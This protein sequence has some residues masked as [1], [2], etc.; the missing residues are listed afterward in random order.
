MITDKLFRIVSVSAALS[1]ILVVALLAGNLAYESYPALRYLGLHVLVDS[2]D[3]A[4]SSYG[5]ASPLITS[6]MLVAITLTLSLP[7]AILF[8]LYVVFYMK[9]S[10]TRGYTRIMIEVLAGIPSVVYGAWGLYSLI[11]LINNYI[12]PVIGSTL[13]EHVSFFEFKPS[14]TGSLAAAS[15]VLTIMVI[16]VMVFTFTE[17][18]SNIPRS[19]YEACLATGATRWQAIKTYVLPASL[20]GIVAGI[21]LAFGR[22]IGETMAVTMVAGASVPPVVPS[23]I[24]SPATPVTTL[25]LVSIGSLTPGYL[26]WHVLFAAALL[27]FILSQVFIAAGKLVARLNHKVLK[28]YT[29]LYTPTGRL[30][31]LEEKLV[32]GLMTAVLV[33]L[34]IILAWIIGDIMLKGLRAIADIG[35]ARVLGNTLQFGLMDGETGFTGGLLNDIIGSIAISFFA[36]V[37]SAPVA[38]FAAIYLVFYCKNKKIISIVEGISDNLTSVPSIMIGM[39]GLAF[40][41][42][43]MRRVTGGISLLSGSL[44]LSVMILPYIMRIIEEALRTVPQEVIEAVYALG[45]TRLHAA[46]VSLR[47]AMPAVISALLLGFL[48]AFSESAPVLLTAGGMSTSL[49]SRLQDPVGNLAVR[50]YALGFEMNIYVNAIKYMYAASAILILIIL[51]LTLALRILSGFS[52]KYTV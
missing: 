50:V 46:L 15:I 2:W 16:P 33:F 4:R 31:A 22:A 26:E 37:L 28:P 3:P 34:A 10:R 14:Y 25:I 47:Q 43:Y 11:P 40:F 13:G 42:I 29:I 36:V 1:I 41:V 52:G 7:V 48:R 38:L 39:F 6:F 23:T 24:F 21:L 49:P 20:R 27:L 30:A 32:L 5:L 51:T 8:S 44:A 12:G 19:E 35:L 18:F 9:S 45:G 17:V